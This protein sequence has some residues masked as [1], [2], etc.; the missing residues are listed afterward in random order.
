VIQDPQQTVPLALSLAAAPQKVTYSLL[1]D[2]A[3]AVGVFFQLLDSA[4]VS[5]CGQFIAQILE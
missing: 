4:A 2:T 3:I 5:V 1:T